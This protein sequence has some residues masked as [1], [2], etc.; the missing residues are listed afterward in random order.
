MPQFQGSGFTLALPEACH[1]ASAYTFVLPEHNGFAP[2]LVIRFEDVAPGT[3]LGAY[4]DQALASL[5][6]Q[7]DGFALVKKVAGKRG[8]WDGVLA[9][10]QWGEGAARMTQKHV[11]M[12]AAGAKARVYVLTATDLAANAGQSN[13]VFDQILR[14]FTP[15]QVQLI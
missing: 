5:S 3:D 1:D 10:V 2:S 6:G 11:Y 4:A 15:N 13:P 9:T 12:L 14:S 7:L 8:D